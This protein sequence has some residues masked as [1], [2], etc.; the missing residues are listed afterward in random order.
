MEEDPDELRSVYD[1]PNYADDVARLKEKLTA[2]QTRYDV[3]AEDPL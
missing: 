2:L 1:D 3:P